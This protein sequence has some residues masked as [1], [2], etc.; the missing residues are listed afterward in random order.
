MSLNE[1]RHNDTG[2]NDTGQNVCEDLL[3]TI[4]NEFDNV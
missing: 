4:T 3:K 1:K 2:Y